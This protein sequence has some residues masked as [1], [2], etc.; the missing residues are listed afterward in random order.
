MA[1]LKAHEADAWLA[2]PRSEYPVVLVYGPDR[3]LVSERAAKFARGTGIGL[4]DPFAVSRMDGGELERD[5]GRLIDE[6]RTV[7]MFGGRRLIWI[8]NSAASKAMSDALRTLCDAPPPET[9]ILLEAGDLKKGV[10]LRSLVEGSTSAVAIPCF[11]DDAGGIDSVIDDVMKEAG[12]AIDP[13]A[14]ALLRRFLGGDRLATRR[15]VEKLALY[16]MG[17][18]AV[19]VVDV[20]MLSGDVSGRSIDEVV[21]AVLAGNIEEFDR[22]FA[23]IATSQVQTLVAAMQRQLEGL[24]AMRGRVEEKGATPAEVV[25]SARPPVFFARRRLIEQAVDRWPRVTIAR[26][27]ESLQAATLAVRRNPSMAAAL[28][29]RTLLQIARSAAAR[30]RG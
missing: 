18:P 30:N 20:Q 24:H 16:A 1:Q 21:D 27:L 17:Q 11:I 22:G 5:P 10:A 9:L 28:V 19:T 26:M 6:A 3:G 29:H 12:L 13:D 2:R 23:R 15:E 7:P 25:G 4:D 8:R 14:R